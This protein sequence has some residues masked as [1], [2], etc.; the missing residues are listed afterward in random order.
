MPLDRRRGHRSPEKDTGNASWTV[1]L[2]GVSQ[3]MN[4]PKVE[5]TIKQIHA[6]LAEIVGWSHVAATSPFYG[7][8]FS[9]GPTDLPV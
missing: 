7:I 4:H 1:N 5:K 2:A 6:N 3:I 9:C 8:I